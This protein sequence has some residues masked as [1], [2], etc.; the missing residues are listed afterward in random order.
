MR[1]PGSTALPVRGRWGLSLALW[2]AALERSLAH[3]G[4]ADAGAIEKYLGGLH[5]DDLAL[6]AA[7]IEGLEPAWE[8][9]I[10]RYRPALLR[11]ADAID[12]SGA[13]A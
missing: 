1:W 7:C 9:F 10:A 8:H 3:A 5:L 2:Q 11:A 4:V 12:P 6:A 13:R